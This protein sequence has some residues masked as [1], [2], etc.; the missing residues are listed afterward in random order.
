MES[1]TRLLT[2]AGMVKIPFFASENSKK[3]R[4]YYFLNQQPEAIA[5]IQTLFELEIKENIYKGKIFQIFENIQAKS[6]LLKE[7]KTFLLISFANVFELQEKHLKLHQEIIQFYKK[8]LEIALKI[9]DQVDEQWIHLKLGN[10]YQGLG[11][12]RSAITY[13]EKHLKIAS[14][15][16]DLASEGI[17]YG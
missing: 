15:L 5:K 17:V 11:D 16:N 12:Y 14:K 6:Y 1:T 7:G 10:A 2:T 13:H 4:L 3:I 8:I 9:R